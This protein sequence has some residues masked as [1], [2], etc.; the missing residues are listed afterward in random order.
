MKTEALVVDTGQLRLVV[1]HLRH[2]RILPC[3][4][5]PIAAD[6]YRRCTPA[7]TAARTTDRRSPGRRRLSKVA[8]SRH[9]TIRPSADRQFGRS[10]GCAGHRSSAARLSAS[11]RCTL[12]TRRSTSRSGR[13]TFSRLHR[14]LRVHSTS[15]TVLLGNVVT[16]WSPLRNRPLNGSRVKNMTRSSVIAMLVAEVCQRLKAIPSTARICSR[17]SR[18]AP[19]ASVTC[20]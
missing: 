13:R 3:R 14:D 15:E 8:R 5:E 7:P 18:S 6:M 10:S 12:S 4:R 2:H 20:R 11:S 19:A 9:S 1:R 17:E 16:A